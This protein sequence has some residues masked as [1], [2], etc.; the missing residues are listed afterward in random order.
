MYLPVVYL[1][2]AGTRMYKYYRRGLS[3]SSSSCRASSILQ[4]LAASAERT[5]P[6]RSLLCGL[7]LPP[8]VVE[9]CRSIRIFTALSFS[10]SLEGVIS[11]IRF[12][13]TLPIPTPRPRVVNMLRTS[14]VAVPAFSLVEPVSN[15]GPA[16]T[17]VCGFNRP[18]A[19]QLRK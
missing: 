14:L 10:L 7:P 11:I 13:A 19:H 9:C 15:S 3:F 8:S 1:Q 2:A 6:S 4:S 5:L 16:N 17:G 18:C 12:D